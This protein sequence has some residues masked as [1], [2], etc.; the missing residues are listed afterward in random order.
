MV[1]ANQISVFFAV[2]QCEGK[3]PLQFIEELRPF[4]LVQRE[5]HFTVGTGLELIAIAIFG[6]QRLVVVD[7]TVDRQRMGFLLVIE[8]LGAGV[9][10]DDRQTFVGEN[11]FIAGI[12]AGPVR[13]A[14]AHQAGKFQCLFTQFA[15]VSFDIQYAKNRT[16]SLLRYPVL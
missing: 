14:V 12:N 6:A 4:F 16:H 8:R 1:A 7:F 9:D 2:I 15:C 11:R 13:S 3:H 10:V 5:D